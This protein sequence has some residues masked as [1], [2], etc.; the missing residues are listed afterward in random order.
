[1]LCVE[2]YASSGTTPVNLNA[3]K[4]YSITILH[5]DD[6]IGFTTLGTYG[7]TLAEAKI[8][9]PGTIIARVTLPCDCK[10]YI[11]ANYSTD[12]S[13]LPVCNVSVFLSYLPR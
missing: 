7:T 6:G 5:S 13:T 12:E 2:E 11:K 10:T 3:G 4:T 9:E 8:A 1:V